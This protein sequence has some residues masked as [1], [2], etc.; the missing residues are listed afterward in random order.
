MAHNVVDSRVRFQG[1]GDEERHCVKGANYVVKGEKID[2]NKFENL[3]VNQLD[4]EIERPSIKAVR[5]NYIKN[6]RIKE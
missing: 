4:I 1:Y 3:E 6:W 5:S 2:G